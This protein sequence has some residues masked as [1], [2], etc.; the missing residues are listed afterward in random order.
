MRDGLNYVEVGRPTLNVGGSISPVGLGAELKEGNDKPPS[1][2]TS[3]V[4]IPSCSI[5]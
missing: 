2:S 4:V 1:F 5:K 3:R